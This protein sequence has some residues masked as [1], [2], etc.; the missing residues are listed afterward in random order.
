MKI[1]VLVA[2]C[3]TAALAQ[4]PAVDWEKQKAETLRHFRTLVQIDT[5]N[6][7]GNEIKAVQY[8]KKVIEA[9]GIPTQTFALDPNRPNLVARLKGNGSKRP[10]LILAHTDVVGVQRGKWPV[11][12]F[13][14]VMKDGYI[15]GR[16]TTDDKDKLTAI[17]MSFLLL[18]RSSSPL[19]RDIIF[20]A[21][22]G[23]EADPTGVGI[24]FMVDQH[25]DAIDA[26]FAIT[27]GPGATIEN[28]RVTT[29]QITTTEKV[30]RRVRL[31]ANGTSGHGSVPRV[32]NALIHLSAAVSKVGT[33]ETPMRLN[34]TTR[35]YFEKL[36]SISPPEKAARYNGLLD[37]QRSGAIQRYL[38][39]NEPMHYSM[40]RTS[41][42]PTMLQAGISPNVIPSEAEATID[43]RAL[44][45]E[46]IAKFYA[47]M[48]RVIGDPAVK[49]VP[50]FAERSPAPPSRLDTDMY[51]ALEQAGKRVYPGSTV[52]PAMLT[53]AT[54]MAQLRAK[55]VQSYGIGPAMTED[56]RTNHAWHSDVERLSEP[57]LYQFVEFTWN[58]ITEVAV[59]K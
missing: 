17:L 39:E 43:I 24:R 18:K 57:A 23:E 38:A 58:A 42:A 26:E 22:S 21:E 7:P 54:D 49:I 11:D 55:G 14:A 19:D 5:S 53:A 41:V 4:T 30:P 45:D 33:W 35:T 10:L 25:F 12:P 36:A 32:D 48:A 59:K 29:V 37:P 50:L 15:W 16:G 28:G 47:E 13:G 9:E 44:P 40:L 1:F 52:L 31:V 6:P 46:D 2:V 56:D 20:L 8:L 51:R 34:D 27:E 3:A